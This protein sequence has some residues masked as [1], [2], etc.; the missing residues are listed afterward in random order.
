[1]TMKPVARFLFL[2]SALLMFPSTTNA[3]QSRSELG[4]GGMSDGRRLELEY[5]D[6]GFDLEGINAP[7]YDPDFWSTPEGKAR[8]EQLRL[9]GFQKNREDLSQLGKED[10]AT[11][12]DSISDRRV[13]GEFEKRAEDLEKVTD[14]II[15]F[16]AWRFEAEPLEVDEPS[17][18]S[19]RDRLVQITP[20]V[21][22]ILET[23]STLAGSGIPVQEFIQMRENLAQIHA[24]SQVLR[25]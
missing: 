8:Y 24:L 18:E 21:E 25:D 9:E 4:S 15:K 20:M 17:E 14:D 22:Q 6:R 23:I 5:L 12:Y 2:A 13:R 11:Q 16:F 1:M 3:Q 19:V 10:W 7:T